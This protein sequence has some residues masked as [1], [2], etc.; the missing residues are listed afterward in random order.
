MTAAQILDPCPFFARVDPAGRARLRAMATL[1]RFSKGETIFRQDDPCPGIYVIGSGQVRIYKISASGKEHVLHIAGPGQTFAEVAVIG[2]F[3]CP[4]GAE[5]LE[6]TECALLPTAAFRSALEQDH[7]L[8][9]AIL[10]SMAHWVRHLVGLMEDLVLRD[11][12]S[13]VARFLAEAE[14][15]PAGTVTLPSLKK[16]LA[17]HLNLTSETLSRSLRRLEESGL[18]ELSAAGAIRVADLVGLKA[19]AALA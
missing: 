4:A 7:A 16:H 5:A 6:P 17:S 2:G 19:L 1:A 9:L 11:A 13:R 8:T 14:R 15:D 12:T 10:G 18:I 3:S